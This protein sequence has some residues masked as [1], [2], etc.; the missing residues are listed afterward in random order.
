[1]LLHSCPDTVHRFPLRKTQTSTPLTQGSFAMVDPGQGITSAGADC[2]YR[3]PLSPRLRGNF[4]TILCLSSIPVGRVFVKW[5]IEKMHKC[6]L[7]SRFSSAIIK[8]AAFRLFYKYT[9]N[10][11]YFHEPYT[12]KTRPVLWNGQFAHQPYYPQTCL[13]LPLS[14]MLISSIYNMADY[15]FC[16]FAGTTSL[17]AL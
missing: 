8:F 17:P 11:E 14:A 10:K 15:I 9:K 12:R 1:M 5:F 7:L 13:R 2:R 16:K 4:I 6:V 3:A